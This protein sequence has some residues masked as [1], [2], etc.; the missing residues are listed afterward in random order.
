MGLGDMARKAKDAL[1]TEKGEQVSD[2]V[3]DRGADLANR[4]T[5][6]KYADKVQQGRDAVDD[7]IGTDTTSAATDP[8]DPAGR[9]SG[10]RR[11]DTEVDAGGTGE[12]EGRH[13]A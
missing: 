8:V 3:L 9:P 1:S 6:E 4:V 10:R 5:G 13:R 7:R 11:A 2:K 12:P